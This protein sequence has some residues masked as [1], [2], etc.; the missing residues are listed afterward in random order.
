MGSIPF[1]SGVRVFE[2][3][4]HALIA[5]NRGQEIMLLATQLRAS[6]KSKVLEVMPLPSRPVVTK[7]EFRSLVLA[8]NLIQWKTGKHP[9]NSGD[10][11]DPF[12]GEIPDRR[13]AGRVVEQ[14]R[15]GAHDLRIVEVLDEQGF[16]TWALDY[17]R[18]Q[19]APDPTIPEVFKSVIGEYLRDGFQWFVFDVVELG[20]EL[21]K[22]DVLR[23]HFKT[24]RL[25]FP[26]RI[27][28]AESGDTLVKLLILTHEPIRESQFEGWPR[29]KIKMPIRAVKLFS[30]EVSAI[31]QTL[32]TL[33]GNDRMALLR[34]WEIRGA[35]S[36]FDRD[37]LVSGAGPDEETS[38]E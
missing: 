24:E 29:A 35:L 23:F 7:G 27:T 38:G 21:V 1:K 12:A 4:Q 19:G 18:K 32:G 2:P 28:R 33:L 36:G 8:N 13:P 14:K 15:I 5:W 16:T 31:D 30:R 26:L 3:E 34:T 11:I 20:P 6:E 25:Y 22:K 10:G 9:S 37:L 17:L